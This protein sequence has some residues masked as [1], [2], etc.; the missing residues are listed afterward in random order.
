MR[1]L[2]SD[3][4]YDHEDAY[5]PE[6]FQGELHSRAAGVS[7]YSLEERDLGHGA[8]WPMFLASFVV[9]FLSG[10]RIN[11]NLDA[12]IALARKF[13][14]FCD[15]IK[16]KCVALWVDED[17]ASALSACSI[18]EGVHAK[19]ESVELVSSTFV[20][21]MKVSNPDGTDP[22]FQPSGAYVQVF[23]TNGEQLHCVVVRSD[24]QIESVTSM[25]MRDRFL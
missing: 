16:T 17:G 25:E 24:G 2:F 6:R 19:V 5:P 21:F 3:P 4:T 23:V 7:E 13:Q 15:W 22:D 12:W 10:K 14:G 8:S 9:L 11:E 20:P 1:I 18:V